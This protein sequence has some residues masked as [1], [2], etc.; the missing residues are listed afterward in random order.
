V[1]ASNSQGLWN[2]PESSIPILIDR[3]FWQTW[4]FRLMS[5]MVLGL[6]TLAV[7]RLRMHQLSKRMDS[8]FQER[9]AE[10]TRIAQE[11]H[12]TLLQSFQGLMLRFQTVDEML[13]NRPEDAKQILEGALD[14][15]DQA[16]S[17][18]RDAI[19]DIR[20]PETLSLDLARELNAMMADLNLE[21]RASG[22]RGPEFGVIVAGSRQ[23]VRPILRAEILRIAREGLRNAFSHG[24]ANRIETEMT[25][26]PH[27]FYLR[28]RDDGV[29][30][31]P[32]ILENGRRTGHWGLVGMA[33]RAKRIGG[34]LDVWSKLGAG[35]EVELR[36]SGRIAYESAPHRSG[37]RIF[38]RRTSQNR[39][40][41]D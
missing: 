22:G 10:R 3:F 40:R 35:T 25:Y 34:Q 19:K 21:A 37:F 9:L 11:L 7:Y 14:R 26:D 32:S 8:L 1:V 4:W 28:I 38:R 31:D 24:N 27:H 16:L 39:D 15:A 29:G 13:P 17:E 18:S 36:L 41:Q 2:G 30:I 5:L 12:D 20:S 23:T 33:E 6:G